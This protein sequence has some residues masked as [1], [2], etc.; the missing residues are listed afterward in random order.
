MG[1]TPAQ[2]GTVGQWLLESRLARGY[3]TQERARSEIERLTGWKIPVSV[4]SEWESGSRVPSEDN[5]A[6]LTEFFGALPAAPAAGDQASIV[7][8]I[9]RQTAVMERLCDLLGRSLAQARESRDAEAIFRE[10]IQE[11]LGAIESAVVPAIAPVGGSA[12]SPAGAPRR[13]RP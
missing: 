8:A 6:R 10:E 13:P 5:Q 9:D 12:G 1:R 11:V 7:A 3:R 4:Y 2:R